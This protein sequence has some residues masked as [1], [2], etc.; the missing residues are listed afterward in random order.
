MIVNSR[1][2]DPQTKEVI[3][4]KTY[5]MGYKAKISNIELI[6]LDEKYKFGNFDDLMHRVDLALE[7]LTTATSVAASHIVSDIK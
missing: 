2:I 3:Y 4:Q 1:L 6:P 5:N 7:A